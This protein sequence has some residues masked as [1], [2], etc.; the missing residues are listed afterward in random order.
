MIQP[1]LRSIINILITLV[2]LV[3]SVYFSIWKVDFSELGKSFSTANYLIPLAL[4]PVVLASFV[5]RALRWKVIIR[6]IY[7]EVGLGALT[8]GVVVG[9]FMNN[10]IP[11]SGELARP[12]ITSQREKSTTFTGLLG[13]IV[14]ERFI[15]V[16]FLLLLIASV[17]AFDSKL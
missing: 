5:V 6:H 1:R 9:Y 15:D 7:P 8:S 13:T 11:R 17:L 4:I 10:V 3:L 16:I 14:V 2:I 12:Y